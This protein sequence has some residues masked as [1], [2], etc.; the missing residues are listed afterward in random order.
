[1]AYENRA[2]AR[3]LSQF[4][5]GYCAEVPS[6]V[7][8]RQFT[9]N[10]VHA[11]FPIR[12]SCAVNEDEIAIELNGAAVKLRELLESIRKTPEHF[13]PL[14]EELW[15]KMNSGG[16][17]TTIRQQ[18]LRFNG[19]LFADARALVLDQSQIELLLEAAQADWQLVEP[20]IFGTLL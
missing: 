14:V 13:A 16:F 8:S 5:S 18:I 19:G 9:E 1:M 17:S 3:R 7:Q 6:M 11:L 4:N 10:L 12:Q 15:S 2:F 20:A